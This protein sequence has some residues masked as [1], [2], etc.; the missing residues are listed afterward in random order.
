VENGGAFFK[1]RHLYQ[2]RRRALPPF[3]FLPFFVSRN[4]AFV[5]SLSPVHGLRR[6]NAFVWKVREF[7]ARPVCASMSGRITIRPYRRARLLS[8]A[9]IGLRFGV[10]SEQNGG[11]CRLCKPFLGGL[12]RITTPAA[13]GGVARKNAALF[14]YGFRKKER[15]ERCFVSKHIPGCSSFYTGTDGGFRPAK[16]ACAAPRAFLL[17]PPP[18]MKRRELR[19]TFWVMRDV[20]CYLLVFQ[21]PDFII[22]PWEGLVKR[23]RKKF[24][25][26]VFE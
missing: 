18:R 15:R 6:K 5:C 19:G 2:A 20:V 13:A 16:A 14:L 22:N 8:I 9:V 11:G 17:R 23:Y 12:P 26:L 25:Q 3:I 21:L 4:A 7:P 10:A 1:S 24:F